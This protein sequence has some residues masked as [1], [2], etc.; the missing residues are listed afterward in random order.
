MS[1]RALCPEC[2][3]TLDVRSDDRLPR[4]W[5]SPRAQLAGQERC[6]ASQAPT[7]YWREEHTAS[8]PVRVK[9]TT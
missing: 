9:R 4:H 3:R 5:S 6:P 1:A 7:R 8:G 2:G